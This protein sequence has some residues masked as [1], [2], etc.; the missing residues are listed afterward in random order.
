MPLENSMKTPRNFIGICGVLNQGMGG[1]TLVYILLGFLGYV[2]YGDSAEGSITLNLP[3]E[4]IPAQ[5]VKILIALAVFCTFGLQFYV[6]L[7]IGWNFIKDKFTKRPLMVN[8]MM[9]TV[10]V[11]A[12]VLLAIAV[13][14]IGPFVNLL[15]AFCFSILGLLAPV[16]IEI[17]TY[18]DEGFGKYN[19]VIFKNVLVCAF[20]IF[21]LIFGSKDAIHEI[22]KLYSPED[23][24]ANVTSTTFEAIKD[25]AETTLSTITE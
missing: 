15:G 14:T 2:K 7:E 20:G 8:Y 22:I 13:P 21:A 4:E 10:L 12:S 16:F 1:V 25:I 17:I 24:V 6:C 23:I 18:W 19:W 9:R 3:T 11:T 5:A